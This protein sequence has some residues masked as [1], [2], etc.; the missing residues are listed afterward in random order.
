MTGCPVRIRGV[1]YHSQRAAARA[2]GVSERTLRNALAAG[3]EDEVG[4][5]PAVGGPRGVPCD[6]RGQLFP[7]R[8][9]AAVA[10]DVSENAVYRAL[11]RAA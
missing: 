3:R 2:L 11:R 6:Y 1:T 5:R 10:F 7:S 4:L 9:A 8:I